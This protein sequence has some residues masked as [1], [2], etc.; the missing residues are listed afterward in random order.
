MLKT[1]LESLSCTFKDL[2]NVMDD[3][4]E[5]HNK[6]NSAFSE[7]DIIVTTGG[8]SMGQLDLIKPYLNKNG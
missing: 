2:G 4:T 5:L 3:E 8:V 6:F 1:L 7:C